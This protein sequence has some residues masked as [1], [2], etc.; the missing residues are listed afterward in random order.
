MFDI[1]KV[2]LLIHIYLYINIQRGGVHDRLGSRPRPQNNDDDFLDEDGCVIMDGDS[3]A[4]KKKLYVFYSFDLLMSFKNLFFV[5]KCKK[6]LLLI[7]SS[8]KENIDKSSIG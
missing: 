3:Y 4:R 6:K 2:F 7:F 8:I 5:L 1:C